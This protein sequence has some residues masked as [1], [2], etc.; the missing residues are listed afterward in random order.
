[1]DSVKTRNHSC[2][3]G[4]RNENGRKLILYNNK[5]EMYSWILPNIGRRSSK[6]EREAIKYQTSIGRNVTEHERRNR[7]FLPHPR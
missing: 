4:E 2:A 1:M 6:M 3:G 7:S 5:R